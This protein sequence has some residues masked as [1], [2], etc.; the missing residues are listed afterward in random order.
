MPTAIMILSAFIASQLFT[1]A[2]TNNVHLNSIIPIERM[3]SRSVTQLRNQRRQV[4]GEISNSGLNLTNW[5]EN[6]ENAC[7]KSFE[8]RRDPVSNPS[9]MAV[10]YNIPFLNQETGVFEAD[11]RLFMISNPT[12]SFIG[13]PSDKIQVALSFNGASVSPIDTNSIKRSENNFA[14]SIMLSYE[15]PREV[16]RGMAPRLMKTYAFVGQVD[17]TL[18]PLNPA[19]FQKALAPNV[20]LNA[21]DSTGAQITTSLA[22][23]ELLFVNGVFAKKADPMKALLAQP[24]QTLVVAPDAPFVVPGLDILIFP[25]GLIITSIWTVAFILTLG[26]GTLSRIQHREQ[27]RESKLREAKG[28][29]SR[30]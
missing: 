17:K 27:F 28:S 6:T 10:C 21:I 23:D 15:N 7:E 18:M 30:I 24:I 16:K 14:S 22:G 2:L 1:T 9:G 26:F 12:E 11:L 3:G 19:G 8:S 29:L 5:D 25:I 20:S 13:V 4:L